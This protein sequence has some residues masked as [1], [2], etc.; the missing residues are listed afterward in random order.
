LEKNMENHANPSPTFRPLVPAC[1]DHGIAR[2]TA[3]KLAGEGLLET[4]AIGRSRYVLVESLE[5][6]PGRLKAQGG[7]K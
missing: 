4:F 7:E 3:F 5:S 2:T 6:L 1:R